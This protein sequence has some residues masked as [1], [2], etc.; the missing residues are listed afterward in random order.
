M[1]NTKEHPVPF[2]Y[3]NSYDLSKWSKGILEKILCVYLAPKDS[4]KQ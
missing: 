3:H 4:L 1:K 2:Y